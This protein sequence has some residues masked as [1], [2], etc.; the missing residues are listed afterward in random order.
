MPLSYRDLKDLL[1]K[2]PPERLDDHILIWDPDTK[3]CREIEN[4]YVNNEDS[5]TSVVLDRGH[6][7][8][9]AQQS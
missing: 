8:L 1:D 6:L 3:E 4:A 2:T 5:L 7:V 9:V